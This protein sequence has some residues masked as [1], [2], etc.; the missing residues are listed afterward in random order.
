MNTNCIFTSAN[1]KITVESETPDINLPS[2]AS[3]ATKTESSINVTLGNDNNIVV[4][5]G[6]KAAY[7]FTVS[8]QGGSTAVTN[9]LDTTS[10]ITLTYTQDGKTC[11]G[12]ITV[13]H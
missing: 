4:T 12:Q 5:T 3:N 2:N 1:T 7:S 6:P 11:T 10:T 9:V 13:H 8:H